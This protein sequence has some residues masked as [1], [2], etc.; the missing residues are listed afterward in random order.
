[1]KDAARADATVEARHREARAMVARYARPNTLR[2]HVMAA[3]A[4]H[5]HL[6]TDN[7]ADCRA[8]V[9]AILDEISSGDDARF[10]LELLGPDPQDRATR[11]HAHGALLE[12]AAQAA[13]R[14]ASGV[15]P[16]PKTR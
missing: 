13:Y 10:L 11:M 15:D 8:L 2:S 1:M 6:C 12:R 3:L 5:E 4:K 7:V 16:S 14:L 9:D